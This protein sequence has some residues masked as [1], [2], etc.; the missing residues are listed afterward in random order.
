MPPPSSVCIKK[1]L[2]A[3][4]SLVS[5]VVFMITK[6]SIKKYLIEYEPKKWHSFHYST[7]IVS[8]RTS[9]LQF[10]SD[11]KSILQRMWRDTLAKLSIN[12]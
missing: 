8:K 11:K 2:L 1:L 5:A 7:K 4:D 10:L 6:K 3:S 12:H 9:R